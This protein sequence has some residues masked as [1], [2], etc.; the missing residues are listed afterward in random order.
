MI[1]GYI[2][3]PSLFIVFINDFPMS[4]TNSNV[5]MYADDSTSTATAKTTQELNVQL[6][7]HAT[8]INTWCSDNHMAANTSNTKV[9][10]VTNWQK[11]LS[12]PTD[13]Q[14]LSIQIDCKKF[15]NIESEKNLGIATNQN[16][17][18]AEHLNKTTATVNSK[19]ALLR[20]IKSLIPLSTLKLFCNTHILPHMDYCSI[21]WCSTPHVHNL[22]LFWQDTSH[23]KVAILLFH[24]GD[25][26]SLITFEGT[27]LYQAVSCF[28]GITLPLAF[29]S[30]MYLYFK[31]VRDK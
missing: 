4:I 15:Q 31:N 2:L 14:K 12:L 13:Q 23:H 16:L 20:K 5:D 18:W 30:A 8:E 29:Q 28:S 25:L 6:N 21:I 26:V 10:L 1:Q 22:R 9:M 11:R 27:I 7:Q 17:S 3:V 24:A 19:A